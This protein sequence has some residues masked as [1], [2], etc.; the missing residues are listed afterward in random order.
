MSRRR[1]KSA[2]AL[3]KPG[4]VAPVPLRQV[5]DALPQHIAVLSG[6]GTILAV[7]LAWRRF[8]E[9][10]SP[11][12]Q[13]LCEGNSYLAAC[14]GE[15]TVGSLE[16]D[17]FGAAI[18]AVIA[19]DLEEFSLEYECTLDERSRW[20]VGHVTRLSD[21]NGACAVVSH[22]EITS[23]KRAE[24]AANRL[25]Y[26][27]PLTGLPN[28]LLLEDRLQHAIAQADRE[29]WQVAVL[30]L[31]LDR[32]K[33]INDTLGHAAGDQLLRAVTERLRSCVRRSDTVARLGGDEF[34]VLLLPVLHPH[35]VT[36]IAAKILEALAAPYEIG[37]QEIVTTASIGIAFCPGDGHEPGMLLRNADMAMYR[38]KE[39]GRNNCQYYT[40]TMNLQAARRLSIETGLRQALRQNGLRLAFQDQCALATGQLF[41]CEALL[42]WEH[43]ERGLLPPLEF[44]DIAE[45]SGLILPIGAWVLQNACEQLAAW[46]GSGLPELLLSINLSPRE[47]AAPGLIGQVERTLAA[48]GIAP[49]RLQ[50]EFT[51]KALQRNGLGERERL[52]ELRRL[53]VQ[54]AIDDFGTGYS[55]ITRLKHLPLDRLKIDHAFV[56]AAPHDPDALAVI[57]T[58]VA[59]AHNLGLRVTAEGVETERQL[60][61]LREAGCDEI[62]GWHC[63][64]PVDGAG[65]GTFL[66]S[67]H[68]PGSAG[69][70]L[71]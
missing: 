3:P 64:L 45:E 70:P 59:V 17:T 61:L 66:D 2:S 53:G 28:R 48:C 38:A 69:R 16:G 14:S 51:E 63:R 12:P 11:T 15:P 67:G 8:A 35:A 65:F 71:P 32:F 30:F 23:L 26:F 18:R 50:L 9:Q 56:A 22:E 27:D 37:G 34:V 57:R 19:G 4:A 58:V 5:L 49:H 60:E 44:L 41:G 25:A 20:F 6:D 62:Q 7:N 1:N 13:Y 33:L 43:P 68:L 31:D 40:A 47:L 29:G 24:E 55:S 52:Q 36:A 10:H 54:L 21:G 46:R 42:R 39:R